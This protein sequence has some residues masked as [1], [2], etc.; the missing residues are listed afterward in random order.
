MVMVVRAGECGDVTKKTYSD[1]NCKNFVKE[2]VLPAKDSKECNE[3][4]EAG[5]THKLECGANMVMMEYK[6]ANCT[7]DGISQ[8]SSPQ[9][10]CVKDEDSGTHVIL[11]WTG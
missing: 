5:H 9:N 3:A 11:S 8:A 6:Q 7:G 1:E 10:R 4:E 2:E